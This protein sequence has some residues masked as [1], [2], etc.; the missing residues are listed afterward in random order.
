MRKS[1]PSF[2]VSSSARKVI[3][4][5]DLEGHAQSWLLACDINQNSAKTLGSCREVLDKF[6][7]FLRQREIASVDTLQIRQFF[8]YL[9]HGHTE[10]GRR[11]I[12]SL[13]A[14]TKRNADCFATGCHRI[15]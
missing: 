11:S 5:A 7:W 2:S 12:E 1:Q 3:P 10:P 14:L 9:A 4:T 8:H 6:L 15:R 13:N